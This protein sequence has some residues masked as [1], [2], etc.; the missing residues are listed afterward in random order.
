MRAIKGLALDERDGTA[1]A[2]GELIAVGGPRTPSRATVVISA[3]PSEASPAPLLVVQ[4]G[5]LGRGEVAIVSHRAEL[6]AVDKAHALGPTKQM[7]GGHTWIEGDWRSLE[8][9]SVLDASPGDFG[10]DGVKVVLEVQ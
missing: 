2:V 4:V 5:P 7:V 10:H 1:Q 8:G 6:P 9:E 3:R